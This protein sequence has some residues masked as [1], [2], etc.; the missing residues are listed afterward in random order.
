MKKAYSK[1]KKAIKERIID[2]S[3]ING[4]ENIFYELCFCILT[5]QSSA[6]KCDQAVQELRKRDFYR[7]NFD[8]APILK[9]LSRFHNTKALR[10]KEMKLQYS[11]I[12]LER[13]YLVSNVKGIGW[14][15]SSHFLRNIGHRD[16]AILDR[17]ILKHLVNHKAIKEIPKTLTPKLYLEIEKK[18]KQF[19]K[20]VKIPMDELDL[21]FWSS[22]TGQIFK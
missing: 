19:S 8:P 16:L 2:F 14:K 6:L 5:P 15:E 7:K 13:D 10:L 22:E 3:K 4:K 20:K 21:L 12:K 11:S 9:G 1:Q 17:H 18:F